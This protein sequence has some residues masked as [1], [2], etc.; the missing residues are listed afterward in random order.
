[1][2]NGVGP[3]VGDV[4]GERV[5]RGI[6]NSYRSSS[7]HSH[8]ADPSPV[9]STLLMYLASEQISISF[10]S[11]TMNIPAGINFKSVGITPLPT[12][13][14]LGSPLSVRFSCLIVRST[15]PLLVTR[16]L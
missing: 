16:Y 3:G 7:I 11:E 5:E 8:R 12:S 1:M 6:M 14:S 10:D 9:T 2:G 13:K 4:V 15:D